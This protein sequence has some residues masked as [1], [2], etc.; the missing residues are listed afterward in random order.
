MNKRAAA[1]NLTVIFGALLLLSGTARPQPTQATA[2]A[3]A[4]KAGSAR[5]AIDR[6]KEERPTPKKRSPM[7]GGYVLTHE[8]PT[9]PMAFGGNYAFTGAP[10]NYRNGVM[11]KGQGTACGGCKML[12]GCDHGEFKGALIENVMGAS[13]MGDHPS[14]RSPKHNAFSHARYSTEWIKEAWKPTDP[15]LRDNRMR[16]FV[17]YAVENEAMCEQLYY[18]NKGKGGTGGDGYPCSHGDS[19]ASMERQLDALKAWAKENSDWMEIAY[20]AAD[21]RRIAAADKL[22]VV[23][24]I[25]AEYAFGAEDRTFDPV[26]RLDRYHASGVRTFY[27]A[28]KINSR[29]AGADVY[30]PSY[31]TPGRTIRATQAIAG[32]FYVDDAVAPFPLKN[33]EGHRFCDNNCGKGY[34]KGNKLFGLTEQCSNRFGEISEANMAD[35][36]LLRADD[37]FNG[38]KV[39]PRLPGFRSQAGI[40]IDKR[41]GIDVE[42]NRLGLSN[43]GERVTRAAMLKGMLVNIDHVSS[44]SRREMQVISK[45]F[46]GYPLNAFHNNPNRML[47]G[48]KGKLDTPF[49]H[50]YDLD[51]EE[52]AMI[53]ESGGFFGVRVGPVDAHDRLTPKSGVSVNCPKTATETAKILAYLIDQRLPVGYGLDFATVTQGVWSRTLADCGRE[54]GGGDKLHRYGDDVAEGLSH[55]GMI[56]YFHRELEAVGLNP[57][58]LNKLKVEGPEAFVTMW[59]RSEAKASVGKQI[60]REVVA[61]TDARNCAVDGDCATSE[62]CSA[63]IPGFDTKSCEPKKS[64]G[65]LCTDKR[66]CA[67]DRCAWGFCAD[68][69]ECRADQHCGKTEYCGDPISGKRSCKELKRQGEL[70]SSKDQCA[71]GRCSW[72]FCAD[73]DECRSNSDCSAGQYCGDPIGSKASCKALL[74]DGAW[75]TK[76]EQCR[77]KKCSIGK[78]R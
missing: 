22:V 30:W 2:A 73:K 36:V 77:S 76:S 69:D 44:Q 18:V 48:N 14:H 60:P 70:C 46:G 40:S 75:C 25:E 17:A 33:A 39:Y 9:N 62:Y 72:G 53:R 74:A 23:L 58:Y 10:G 24:G 57:H 51:D 15:D 49:P 31:S 71:S 37:T 56:K 4:P 52:L 68:P 55:V 13:D 8:H 11:V 43:D 16:V 67:S 61:Q 59:E 27:L 50:E 38:F 63:G 12:S 35:Y 28:H 66:Q 78:C 26:E 5:S 1:S 41:Y 65:V 32:C 42:R 19:L 6:A 29:L 34:F 47:I 3:Q 7:P 20:T 54:L 45:D 64:R 21:A